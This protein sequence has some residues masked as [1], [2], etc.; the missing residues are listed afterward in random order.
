MIRP[1]LALVV[2]VALGMVAFAACTDA[3]DTDP[4]VANVPTATASVP[5]GARTLAEF[6]F[7]HGPARAISLPTGA[8]IV[9]RTD[10][11]NVLTA[12]VD[13]PAAGE[14]ARHLR[15]TLPSG[16]FSITADQGAGLI[17][18]GH[19]WE[20]AFAVGADGNGALSLRLSGQ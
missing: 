16:G 15:A 11:R 17:F 3:P 5:V 8:H 9:L 12:V 20:G 19:G 7:T 14:V 18:V 1:S 6:G 13:R 2:L 4:P 10:Q